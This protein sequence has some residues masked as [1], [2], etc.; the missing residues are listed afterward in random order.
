MIGNT[1]VWTENC[2]ACPGVNSWMVW[3]DLSGGRGG[4]NTT[5]PGWGKNWLVKNWCL[6]SGISVCLVPGPESVLVSPGGMKGT[7]S[8]VG[9]GVRGY[10]GTSPDMGGDRYTGLLVEQGDFGGVCCGTA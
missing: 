10:T 4:S 3:T 5:W 2:P 9:P 6:R 7:Q 1:M 8:G